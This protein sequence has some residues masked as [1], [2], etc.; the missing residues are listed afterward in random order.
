VKGR[1]DVGSAITIGK[2][3]DGLVAFSCDDLSIRILDA[4]APSGRIVR[5]LWGHSNR[6]TD[7]VPLFVAVIL[8]QVFSPTTSWIISVS[9]DSTLRVWDLPTGFLISA[10]QLPSVATAIA[11]SPSGEFL[12]TTHV[13]SLAIHLW[14][15]RSQFRTIPI[16]RIKEEDIPTLQE[17]LPS[18]VGGRG[19]GVLAGAFDDVEDEQDDDIYASSTVDQL[20]E[21]LLTLSFQPR[22]KMW[23]LLNLEA[24][25][26]R[27]RAKEPIK[28]PEKAPFFLPSLKDAT[29]T[30]EGVEQPLPIAS[31]DNQP[32]SRIL[33]FQDPHI[34]SE[35]SKLLHMHDYAGLVPHMAT[36]TPSQL[37]YSIRT[38]NL[39]SP[40]TEPIC[41][42]KALTEHARVKKDFELV[43][44]WMLAFL[45]IQQDWLVQMRDVDAIRE[46]LKK[47]E[48]VH[49]VERY[50]IGEIVGYVSGVLAFIR[51]I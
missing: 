41:F 8:L 13:G 37:D 27:N 1:I 9:L 40:F 17:L 46:V 43:Q 19:E 29:K 31:S 2:M 26:R 44:A 42:V 49:R 35:F 39:L 24:I 34:E 38:M 36:L 21:E 7:F 3:Q 23:S 5:E 15:N 18:V 33:R 32:K 10:I 28:Q 16:R 47:W 20:S 11:F 12:A 25:R 6:I 30:R 51:G 4:E 22:T 50:R 14:S 48:E 45:R